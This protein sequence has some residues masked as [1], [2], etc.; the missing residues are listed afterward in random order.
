VS[1]LH[2]RVAAVERAVRDARHRRLHAIVA[3]V[4]DKCGIPVEGLIREFE[5]AGP[6]PYRIS[7]LL[8]RGVP[9]REIVEH[10]ATESG[11]DV[12]QERRRW[13]RLCRRWGAPD[14]LSA[15]PQSPT[16]AA[17]LPRNS[18]PSRM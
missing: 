4:A 10:L 8:A 6:T 13:E 12:D 7:E 3:A 15:S 18:E 9:E 17:A 1:A 2:R 5:R 14:L 16:A 11:G